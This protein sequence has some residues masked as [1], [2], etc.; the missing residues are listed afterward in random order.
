MREATEKGIPNKDIKKSETDKVIMYMLGTVLRRF[1]FLMTAI[2]SRRFPAK[3]AKL[4]NSIK[5]HSETL[6]NVERC[7]NSHAK[8]ST[9]VAVRFNSV[10]PWKSGILNLIQSFRL[11]K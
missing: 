8:V 5:K 11:G 6:V 3:E 2:P 9:D 1:G 7:F 4:I 10:R